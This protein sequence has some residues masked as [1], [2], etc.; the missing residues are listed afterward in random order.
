LTDAS[1][2]PACDIGQVF[3]SFIAAACKLRA[4]YPHGHLVLSKVDVA[5]AFRQLLIHPEFAPFFSYTWGDFLVV[6]LRLAFGWLGSP[7]FFYRWAKAL[8]AFVMEKTPADVTDEM[9]AAIGKWAWHQSIEEPGTFPITPFP[10]SDT[11]PP[12]SSVSAEGNAPFYFI[13]PYIDDTILLENNVDDRPR[14]LGQLVIFAH[15]LLYGFP[16]EGWPA[17]L[18]EEKVTD[19]ASEGEV[20]GIMV[21]LNTM[22]L[23]LPPKKLEEMKVL[24][25]EEWAPS[26][27]KATP[28]QIMVLVGKLRSWSMCVRHGQYFLRRIIDA[29]GGRWRKKKLDKPFSLDARGLQDD[30]DVWRSLLAQP[31]LLQSNFASPLYNH[32]TRKPELLVISD[33]C[34]TAGGGF[35]APLGVFW[36]HVWPA[37]VQRRF[38]QPRWYLSSIGSDILIHTIFI[39]YYLRIFFTTKL[40]FFVSLAIPMDEKRRWCDV[41]A[42]FFLTNAFPFD[43]C[44][45]LLQHPA[46]TGLLSSFSR[47][48]TTTTCLVCRRPWPTSP[49]F[50]RGRASSME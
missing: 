46:W 33:A 18:K 13:M 30:L 49:T 38:E 25:C 22:M 26:R 20:L 28:R 50:G 7:G 3:S 24:I 4:K 35:I 2:V 42:S 27:T 40:P 1:Q 8:V 15:F 11:S 43:V 14:K 21:N 23:S 29:I 44:F 6:D 19:W 37:E 41:T 48:S 12:S 36:Q 39:F 5:D 47:L 45:F 9:K 34:K 16:R 32:V 10:P 31:K 17:C